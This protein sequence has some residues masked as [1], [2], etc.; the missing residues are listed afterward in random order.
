MVISKWHD[1]D[2]VIETVFAGVTNDGILKPTKTNIL[3]V[4]LTVKPKYVYV[5]IRP[6]TPSAGLGR[7][8]KFLERNAHNLL[9]GIISERII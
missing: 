2:E 9:T 5:D 8:K 7:I 4:L 1:E 3:R 6:L